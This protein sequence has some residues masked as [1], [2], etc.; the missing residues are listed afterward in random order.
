MS[1]IQSLRDWLAEPGGTLPRRVVH[2]GIWSF[3]LNGTDK[4][5]RLVRIIV[6]AR[7]LA[8]EDF[9]LFGITMLALSALDR[10]TKTGFNVALIQKPKDIR[11]DLDTAWL[12]Q[13]GR[14]L[15]LATVLVAIAPLVASFFDEPDA[16]TL[17]RWLAVVA[18]LRGFKNIG[19][20]YFRKEIEFHK[21]FIFR[22]SST[23]PDLLVALTTAVILQNAWALVLGLIAG[24]LTQTT[25][26]YLI[27]PYRPR[28]RFD[29]D[30]AKDL[31][32]FGKYITAQSTVLFLLTEGDDVIVGKV[33]GATSLG[34][35]QVAYKL[36]NIAATQ[37]TH[38]ISGVTFPAYS[39]LQAQPRKLQR[40]LLRTLATVTFLALPVAGGLG[41]LAPD[42]TSIFLGQQWL[43]MVPAMQAMCIF[44]ALRAI[45]A[46]FGPVY[47]ALARVDVPLKI[48]LT[49]LVVLGC[50]I[51]P[52]ML[53]WDILGAS[54]AITIAM[55]MSWIY[56]SH[57]VV[58][59]VDV[60]LWWLYR[61]VLPPV[62]GTTVAGVQTQ[63]LKDIF[64][65]PTPLLKLAGLLF[66]ASLTY[67]VVTLLLYR[68]L[69]YSKE[70]VSSVV[71][72]V[73]GRS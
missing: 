56:T 41:V 15:I 72:S 6:L 35:Y 11:N 55:F 22:L 49:Q 39:K 13:V 18:A 64:P 44:G 9:G 57:Q 59:I 29:R 16:A 3:L 31:F 65:V 38:V 34:L 73:V 12:I 19:V 63:V 47:R 51:Y 67:L 70:N 27:H 50:L 4:L 71:N 33:L 26:S 10:L 24:S 52:F 7:L 37:I 23:V 68:A 45:S 60:T 46:T 58:R 30:R 32:D 36:S 61:P 53:H 54:L 5:L 2:G 43:P 14:G 17:V 69:G 25:F 48:S 28:F 62:L 1:N 42:I 40:A 20:V 8:P 66:L 21:Q